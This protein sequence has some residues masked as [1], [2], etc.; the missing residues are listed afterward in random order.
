MKQI[1]TKRYHWL[2]VL[3]LGGLTGCRQELIAPEP[4][5]GQLNLSQYL[6][7][8]DAYSAGFRDTRWDPGSL[9]G[10]YPEGQSTSYPV[11]LAGQLALATEMTFV[12]PLTT[13]DGSGYLALEKILP[14]SCPEQMPIPQT[15]LRHSSSGWN[16]P[17]RPPIHSLA[18]PH[19]R[20]SQVS[21]DSL[22]QTNPFASRLGLQ[23]SY[24]D[25]LATRSYTFA[26][27]WLGMEDLVDRAMT[28][29]GNVAYPAL[30][31]G[32]FVQRYQAVLSSLRRSART[33][34]LVGNLPDITTFPFV[35]SLP[36]R[37]RSVETCGQAPQPIYFRRTGNTLPAVATSQDQIL[38]TARSRLGSSNSLPGRLGLHPEN[39]LP[40][41]LVLDAQERQTLQDAIGQYNQSLDS[42]VYRHNQ[43]AG[44]QQV[45]VVDLR[46]LFE[47]LGE[48]MTED[49][50]LLTNAYLEGGVFAIDGL[51]F[52]SRGQA[53]V[54]NAF[55][56]AINQ[57]AE[58]DASIPPLNLTDFPGIIF[59]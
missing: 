19:L 3:L 23:G 16:D 18:I 45:V 27:L 34:V 44:Y 29:A 2:W 14:P 50:L 30:S 10:L 12:Q 36:H 58:W 51:Y 37:Y 11:L 32:S 43:E 31:V 20:L 5:P 26:T 8:G 1:A 7:W 28:G 59:P 40:N 54:A 21:Q 46:Q 56:E 24:V 38:L 33:H 48:G 57:A 49:G 52:T 25:E 9:L 13:G 6:A 53:L 41:T 42:L 39:P 17:A 4:T 55:I 47:K 22:I 35:G 15:Q